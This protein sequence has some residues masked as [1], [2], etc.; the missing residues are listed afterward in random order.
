MPKSFPLLCVAIA[1]VMLCGCAMFS[2]WQEIPPPGGCDQC[3]TLPINADWAV[4]YKAAIL[5]DER[6]RDY[7]KTPEYNMPRTGQPASSL[8]VRKVAEQKCFDCH[9]APNFSHKGR[10]GSFH[11][12]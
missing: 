8:E 5:S 1:L 10:M 7:F 4:A 6:N 11:H 2:A 9:K 3:H 12:H